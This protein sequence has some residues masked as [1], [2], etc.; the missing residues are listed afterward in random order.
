MA[1]EK[2]CNKAYVIIVVIIFALVIGL[3]GWVIW[4]NNAEPVVELCDYKNLKVNTTD[5]ATGSVSLQ[6]GLGVSVDSEERVNQAVLNALVSESNFKYLKK[7]ME[8]RYSEFMAYYQQMAGIYDYSSV[9]ELAINYYGYKNYKEFS[10]AVEEY[11]ETAIKQEMVLSE[12]AKK[13]GFTVTDE[14]FDKYI[15]KYLA[16]YDYG[17]DEVDAFLND[18]G[19]ADVYEVILHDYTLDMVVEWTGLTD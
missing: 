16:A 19:R 4:Y 7:A 15:K 13:E 17:E 14:I 8:E 5:V 2:K 11:S 3:A 10:K 18:Y 6:G 12:I 9:E 1:V